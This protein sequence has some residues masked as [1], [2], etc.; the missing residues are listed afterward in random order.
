[1]T[2]TNESTAGY[3]VMLSPRDR[4]WFWSVYDLDGQARATGQDTDREAAW[5]SGMFA[6]AAIGA[7][8]RVGERRF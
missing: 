8:A 4:Y 6:A 3:A 7:L 1:M 5:R 2:Q